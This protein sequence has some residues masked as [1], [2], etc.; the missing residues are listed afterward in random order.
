VTK[1]SGGRLGSGVWHNAAQIVASSSAIEVFAIFI[2]L[3]IMDQAR[4]MLNEK[5]IY[6]PFRGGLKKPETPQ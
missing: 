6:F 4:R 1:P 3:P 5:A 2:T